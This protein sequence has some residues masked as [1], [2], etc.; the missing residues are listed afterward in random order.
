[1]RK[2]IIALSLI[3]NH[4]AVFAVPSTTAEKESLFANEISKCIK[5]GQF[6]GNM[7]V[8]NEFRSNEGKKKDSDALTLSGRLGYEMKCGKATI[9]VEG[10]GNVGLTN[11]YNTS[12]NGKNDRPVIA[13]RDSVEL[14]Q[15]YIDYDLTDWMKIKAGRQEIKWGDE[16]LI[17]AVGWRNLSTSFDAIRTFITPSFMKDLSVEAS[18]LNNLQNIKS[19]NIGMNTVLARVVYKGFTGQE[20]S[21]H[22]ILLDYD[23][24]SGLSKSSTKT[25]GFAYSGEKA[26]PKSIH[27]DASFKL[28]LQGDAQKPYADNPNSYDVY[29]VLVRGT[30]RVQKISFYVGNELLTSDKGKFAFARDLATLHAVNGWADQFLKTPAGGLN[31]FEVGTVIKELFG[32]GTGDLKVAGHRFN[33]EETSEHIGDEVDLQYTIPADFIAPGA[34][35]L[36]KGTYYMGDKESKIMPNDDVMVTGQVVVPFS[37]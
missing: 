16:S 12:L 21:G 5:D 19:Q 33:S 20:V 36:A 1:M 35:I 22:A 3:L 11:G 18:Y 25:F 28:D 31:D 14:N 37:K 32:K 9:F 30:L 4:T 24:D 7:R 15:A 17:G 13:D 34:Q 8:R 10:Q 23:E 27:S 2:S 29:R 6:K 26:L